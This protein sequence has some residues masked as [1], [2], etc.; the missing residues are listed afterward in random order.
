MQNVVQ[1]IDQPFPFLVAQREDLLEREP[2]VGQVFLD[3]RP[4]L[5]F[6]SDACCLMQVGGQ[7]AAAHL[8]AEPDFL[9]DLGIGGD[10]LLAS[11][12]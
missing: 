5:E 2:N 11:D 9:H 3:A 10:R 4:L 6:V 1:P 7:P 8:Q 12:V